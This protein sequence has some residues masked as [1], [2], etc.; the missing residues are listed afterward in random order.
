MGFVQEQDWSNSYTKPKK[1]GSTEHVGEFFQNC[2]VKLRNRME[3]VKRACQ[4]CRQCYNI[5]AFCEH[6]LFFDIYHW[7]DPLLTNGFTLT[8]FRIVCVGL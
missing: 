4:V 1:I 2:R 8:H 6:S 7:A 3:I 5:S